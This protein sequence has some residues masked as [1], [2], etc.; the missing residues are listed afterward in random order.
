[1][2]RGFLN[3][4]L[5]STDD[6]ERVRLRGFEIAARLV[7]EW[8]SAVAVEHHARHG[9]AVESVAELLVRYGCTFVGVALTRSYALC[10]Q[11]G[12]GDILRVRDKA[13]V[14]RPIVRRVEPYAMETASL[15]LGTFAPGYFDVAVLPVDSATRMFLIATDGYS[16]AFESEADFEAVGPDL[17][18]RFEADGFGPVIAALPSWLGEASRLGSGDDVTALV[19]VRGSTIRAS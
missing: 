7:D 19:A 8:S 14:D 18:G 2:L 11:L 1:M 5:S 17:L 9:D 6:L 15:A 4:P 13:S 12:D 16:N 10:L 3:D